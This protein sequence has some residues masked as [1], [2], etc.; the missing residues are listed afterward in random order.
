MN[1]CRL[2][3]LFLSDLQLKKHWLW[4]TKGYK[5]H[6]AA[7][8]RG[9]RS[10]HVPT[11]PPLR[12]PSSRSSHAQRWYRGHSFRYPLHSSFPMHWNWR[13][14]VWYLFSRIATSWRLHLKFC[15]AG[16]L[17]NLLH[18][19]LRQFG[20]ILPLHIGLLVHLHYGQLLFC[21]GISLLPPIRHLLLLRLAK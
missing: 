7:C 9:V 20:M 14:L 6:R 1:L 2:S 13:L 11:Y 19:F 5:R 3:S 8:H 15:S 10:Q 12:L 17:H 18:R 4:I 16:V 21:L